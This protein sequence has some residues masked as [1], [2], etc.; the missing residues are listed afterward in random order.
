MMMVYLNVFYRI[1]PKKYITQ[2]Q[3]IQ[4]MRIVFNKS[5]NYNIEKK[6]HSI[7]MNFDMNDMDQMDWRAFLFLL[8]ILMQVIKPCLEHMKLAYALFSSVGVLDYG[9]HELLTLSQ[10]KDMIETPVVLANRPAIRRLL[11]DAWFQLLRT[12]MDAFRVS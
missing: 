10:V 12:N 2:S 1:E 5:F 7:Y 3:F 4:V 11:D 6:L 8:V 9:C